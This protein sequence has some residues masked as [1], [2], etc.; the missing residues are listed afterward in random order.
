M[1]VNFLNGTQALAFA[2]ERYSADDFSRMNQGQILIKALVKKILSPAAWIRYPLVFIEAL[3]AIDT[4][5]PWWLFPRL[6]FAFLRSGPD[7]I[8]N[9]TINRE[10]VTPFI[11]V[12][13]AQVLLPNW[14]AINPILFEMFGE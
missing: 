13:G 2:R 10:M 3:Q 14:E 12:E 8:D 6:G 1:G 4:N 11:T 7:G 9:R 5:I